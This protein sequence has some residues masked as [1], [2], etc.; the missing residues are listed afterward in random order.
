MGFDSLKDDTATATATAM[1][2]VTQVDAEICWQTCTHADWRTSTG[3]DCW[4]DG[5]S[6]LLASN[7]SSFSEVFRVLP[8]SA[9]VACYACA[10]S[11]LWAWWVSVLVCWNTNVSRRE[12]PSAVILNLTLVGFKIRR[13]MKTA[14]LSSSLGCTVFNLGWMSSLKFLR[15]PMSVKTPVARPST[16]CFHVYPA[17]L[18]AFHTAFL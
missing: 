3:R 8:L 6:A 5:Q 15:R 9:H 1:A 10:R 14:C 17:L 7:C 11:S 12:R 4:E 13:Q 16:S 2:T 18:K